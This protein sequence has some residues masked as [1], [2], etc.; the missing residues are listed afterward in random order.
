MQ[1]RESYLE[2]LRYIGGGAV[3]LGTDTSGNFGQA[4]PA[5]DYDSTIVD[6]GRYLTPFADYES[7]PQLSSILFT[8]GAVDD[9]ADLSAEIAAETPLAGGASFAQMLAYLH[10]ENTD[11]LPALNHRVALH[12][13]WVAAGRGQ[14]GVAGQYATAGRSGFVLYS[15]EPVELERQ[16]TEA[17]LG[18]APV[19]RSLA[20]AS[21]AG[22]DPGRGQV[23][24]NLF[25]PLF[26][27]AGGINWPGNLKKLKLL[28]GISGGSRQNA[29]VGSE[30]VARAI[31]DARGDPGFELSGSDRG[32]IRFDALTYWT[33]PGTLPPGDGV[34]VPENADGRVVARGGA[35][36]KIDGLV[37]WGGP[38]GASRGILHR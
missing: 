10:D 16:L 20:A 1:P 17:L 5:P 25:V 27:P 33:D 31:V 22:G 29:A 26:Q 14:E 36:Q 19:S 28:D 37:P 32:S 24:D 8:S 23:L 34:V 18:V 30:A 21:F 11:L 2:W 13:T 35:G 3:A 4:V 6:S 15:D 12:K 9:D 38:C 7:C